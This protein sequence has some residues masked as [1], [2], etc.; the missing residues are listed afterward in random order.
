MKSPGAR[1]VSVVG[2]MAGTVVVV[3]VSVLL[4]RG[5]VLPLWLDVLVI[6]VSGKALKCK[7]VYVACSTWSWLHTRPIEAQRGV[8]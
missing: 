5:G 3:D 4:V 8:P 2:L 7:T 1:V 6:Y